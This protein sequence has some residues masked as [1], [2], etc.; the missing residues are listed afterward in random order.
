MTTPVVQV[1]DFGQLDVV[2]GVSLCRLMYS[3]ALATL[4]P[5][6]ALFAKFKIMFLNSQE[7]AQHCIIQQQLLEMLRKL[8]SVY[9]SEDCWTAE[10]S[11]FQPMTHELVMHLT[12]PLEAQDV[13]RDPLWLERSTVLVTSNADRSVV[14][15]H[16]ARTLAQQMGV[17]LF[18]WCKPIADSTV[19]ELGTAAQFLF[20]ESRYPVLF[21]YFF[22]GARAQVLDNGNGNV[23]WGVANGT[24]CV[25]HSIAWDD[26]A[27]TDHVAQLVS[28]ALLN[29]ELVVDL[30]FPPEFINVILVDRD[31]NPLSAS[32]WPPTENV[33]AGTD[34]EPSNVVIP[35]G[36]VARS[37]EKFYVRLELP[38]GQLNV[39][40]EQHAVDLAMAMTIWKAQGATLNRVILMLEPSKHSPSWAYEHLYVAVS[41]VRASR[42]FR[43]L[44]L[45]SKFDRKKL[46][47]LIPSIY[48]VRWRMDVGTDGYWHQRDEL[49]RRQ[50]RKRRRDTQTTG[51]SRKSTLRAPTPNRYSEQ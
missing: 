47:K 37:T 17:L 25:Y 8:P 3:S 14:N 41:R 10:A 1:G 9:P 35:I 20:R 15:G 6:K 42:D 30:P 32:V 39:R 50:D 22:K 13:A 24:A 45:S 2:R 12:Q 48:T 28:A 33:A 26:K 23:Q 51:K 49:T 46:F 27:K 19:R 44:P 34:R 31:G 36:L 7:R 40:Y 29:E 5:S 43:C 21:G 11:A 18:R 16:M 4:A 38:S